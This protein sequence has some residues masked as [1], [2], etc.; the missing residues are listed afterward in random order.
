MATKAS[1]AAVVK[2]KG[3]SRA[4]KAKGK[5]SQK[6]RDAAKASKGPK[7]AP[8]AAT[9]Q[10]AS[11]SA[12][13]NPYRPGSSY[14]AVVTALRELGAGEMHPYAKIVPGMIAAMGPD[15][16]AAFKAREPRNKDTHKQPEDRLLVNVAVVSRQKDYGRPLVQTGW[17]VRN[18]GRAKTAGI[19]KL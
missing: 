12:G 3:K 5:P 7:I 9:P 11:G 17:C 13:N 14:A 1:K 4:A 19:F 10:N 2:G 18:D 8:D 15:K 6:P 16:W